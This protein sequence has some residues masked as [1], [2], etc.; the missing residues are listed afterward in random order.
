MWRKKKK[1][2][3]VAVSESDQRARK[4]R[5]MSASD[6][7]EQRGEEEEHRNSL[8]SL[9]SIQDEPAEQSALAE[10][11][12]GREGEADGS[13]FSALRRDKWMKDRDASHC[14]SCESEFTFLNRK[15]HCCKIE[16]G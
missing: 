16:Y 7:A 4:K 13:Q 5:K 9:E 6:H 3:L 8:V 11:S 12:A 15:H 10:S 2:K 1:T 14:Y